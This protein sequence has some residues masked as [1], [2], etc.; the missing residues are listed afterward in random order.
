M[1]YLS[2]IFFFFFSKTVYFKFVR[3]TIYFCQ[4]LVSL[5]LS[6]I[7]KWQLQIIKPF[8]LYLRSKILSVEYIS[9][10][11]H[12]NLVFLGH[13]SHTNFHSLSIFLTQAYSH[14]TTNFIFC[15][16]LLLNWYY[17]KHTQIHI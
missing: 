9:T 10:L 1:L 8:I 15:V 4:F 17:Y 13:D 16:I 7:I 14:L 2:L 6:S 11:R 3:I 12:I 5:I